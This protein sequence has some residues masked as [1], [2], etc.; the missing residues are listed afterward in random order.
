MLHFIETGSYVCDPQAFARYPLL[1]ML[2]FHIHAYLVASK[3]DVAELQDHAIEA[4]L[5]IAGHELEQGFMSLSSGKASTIHF[6]VPDF[7]MMSPTDGYSNEEPPPTPIDRFLNSLVL[8]WKNTPTRYDKMRIAVLEVIK[9]YL[10]KLLQVPFFVTLMTEIVGFGDD[11]V[12]SLNE[13][14]FEVHAFQGRISR[15]QNC[16]IWFGV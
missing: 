16:G 4:Y 15:M 2:D 3:Y 10:N 6:P 11:V 14:G 9:R 1:T 12:A 7:P 13:D 5:S 8:L